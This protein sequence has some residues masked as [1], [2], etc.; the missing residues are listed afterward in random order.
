MMIRARYISLGFLFVLIFCGFS[1]I[2]LNDI[3]ES[4]LKGDYEGAK[5]LA[6]EFLVK[7][8]DQSGA[9]QAQYYFAL[10]SLYLKQYPQSV[11]TLN[12]I[13]KTPSDHLWRDKAYLA[14]IDA[15]YLSEEYPQAFKTAK[16]FL[17]VSRDSEYLSLV[18]LKMAKTSLKLAQWRDARNYLNKI[19]KECPQSLEVNVAKQLLEEKQYFAVQVGSFMDRAR[20]ESLVNELKQK[21]EYAYIVEKIDEQNRKFYRVR[22]GELAILD[23]AKELRTRLAGQGYPTQIFP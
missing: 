23:Q 10:S 2:A 17:K 5:R 13:I 9:F 3:E 1:D 22:V 6:Q 21:N 12:K 11:E 15:Y 20:A 18:Y 16:K 19:I 7:N 14:L 8:Q 4:V